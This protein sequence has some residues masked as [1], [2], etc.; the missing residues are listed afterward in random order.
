MVTVSGSVSPVTAAQIDWALSHG[1]APV[2]L[3]PRA[4]LTDP[5]AAESAAVSACR[6]A[7]SEGL[8]PLVF[9]ARGPDDP[10]VARLAEARARTAIDP[11]TAN[12]RIGAAL[13]RILARTLRDTG[14]RRAVIS[15][16]DTSGHASRQLG[17]YALTALAPTIPGASILR[18]WSDDPVFDGLELALKGGQMG[19]ED[20]FGRVRDGGG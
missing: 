7:L 9:T 17:L 6:A 19:A 8:D 10:A 13:G 18:A 1:F 16:G 5:D 20:Y 14:T 12:T 11:E 3:D 15:G 4:L 2:P